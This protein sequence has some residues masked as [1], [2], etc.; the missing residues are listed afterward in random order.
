MKNLTL[1][2]L[3]LIA[4]NGFSQNNA[5]VAINDTI[6]VNHNDSITFIEPSA[7]LITINDGD[8]DGNNIKID[9]AFY[10]GVG[11]FQF[12]S[13]VSNF[14]LFSYK[15][16]LNYWGIDSAQYILKDDGIPIMYD[17]ATIYFFVKRKTY[18][19]LDLNNINAKVDYRGLFQ[20][21]D[22]GIAAFEVPKGSGQNT[23][24]AANLWVAGK[25]LDSIYSNSETFNTGYTYGRSGPIM[26]SIHYPTHYDYRWDRVWKI[27]NSDIN[28]WTTPGY[29]PPQVFLDWPAEGELIKGQAFRLAPFVDNNNDNVYNPY[30]GDY[31]KIKGQ[32]AIYFMYNDMREKVFGQKPMQTEVHGMA[33]AYNCFSDS[34][35]NNTI[36]LDYTIY[37]RSNLTYD[38]TY[39]GMWTDIDIGGSTD[40]Y[41]GCDVQR[42]TFYGY[43]GDNDD[44]GGNGGLGY[45]IHPPA[46]G[47][48]FLQ[49]AKQDDDGID[50]PL[51]QNVPL[52]LANNGIVYPGLGVGFGDGITDN[53][54]WGLEHFSYYYNTGVINSNLF[55][56]NYLR[57]KWQNGSQVVWGG[58]GNAASS[59]GTIPATHMFPGS[60]VQLFYSTDGVAA[61]PTNWSEISSGQPAGD[62][63]AIGSTGPF[64]FEPDSSISI[65]LAYVFGRDY[66]TTGNQAG[67]VV[68]QERID[69]IR[70][71]YLSDFVTV[72]GGSLGVSEKKN[73][74]NSLLVYPNPFNNE[75]TINYELKNNAATL[76]IYNLVREQIKSQTISQNS[77]IIDLSNQTNGI[78]FVTITDGTTRISKKVLKQ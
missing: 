49:G 63:R 7:G 9:T 64:T 50:N 11:F 73:Q 30:D 33:Y 14:T 4:I 65:T 56:Y 46:Q 51:T 2:T 69:S 28:N 61:S 27:E 78:Y 13:I 25:N 53:E 10:S 47:V 19:T 76:A 38:S 26:D 72:C 70:S 21:P 71:Y 3:L 29:Q 1:I 44:E 39:I 24:Y 54:Y 6:Y 48:T 22:N 35:L 43:N 15:P 45:G 40:D 68:M 52:A 66:Q 34:A 58:N 77:T 59:G 37:N 16:P 32:Q 74:E 20:D 42:S 17:T 55:Y 57:S 62:R 60:S 12:N 5:P 8:P 41:V 36:F 31:P 18:E 23:I 67:I 75:L